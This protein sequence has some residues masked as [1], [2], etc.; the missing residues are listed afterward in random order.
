MK[1]KIVVFNLS[2]AL[3]LPTDKAIVLWCDAIRHTGIRPD[4]R[5]IY[6]N[7]QKN[8]REE[9]IPLLAETGEWT[10]AQI[11]AVIAN[12]RRLFGDDNFNSQAGLSEKME[13]LK[14][15]GYDLG[16]VTN[17]SAQALQESFLDIGLNPE[18]FK[19]VHTSDSG[20]YK[21][22]P[23]VFDEVLENYDK[24]EVLFIGTSPKNDL[25]TAVAAGIDFWAIASA[26]YPQ[27]LFWSRGLDK[28]QTF[29]SI[30]ESIDRLL[31]E[32]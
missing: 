9:I 10:D 31:A 4:E 26:T 23:R 30:T 27:G 3:L 7:Y 22:D 2:G 24:S 12:A 6:S 21:P 5:L 32:D 15:R 1:K 19:I 14:D 8:F 13:A 18:W 11:Q 16:V 29:E 20:V 25:P 17:Q 28:D